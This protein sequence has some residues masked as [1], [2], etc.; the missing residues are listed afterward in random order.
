MAKKLLSLNA[1]VDQVDKFQK[2]T[3]WQHFKN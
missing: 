2:K 3:I 1:T